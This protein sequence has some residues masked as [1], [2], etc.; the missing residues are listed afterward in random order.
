MMNEQ[1]R[2]DCRPVCL[3]GDVALTCEGS[4]PW[5]HLHRFD[6]LFKK[7][8]M[9]AIERTK[10]HGLD[11]AASGEERNRVEF[12]AVWHQRTVEM[13]DTTLVR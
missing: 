5:A 3:V 12:L 9:D 4:A 1:S 8:I 11:V 13:F 7:A 6:A 10:E 2:T